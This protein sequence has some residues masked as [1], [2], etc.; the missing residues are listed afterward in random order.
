VKQ[1]QERLG[2]GDVVLVGIPQ[3]DLQEAERSQVAQAYA[4]RGLVSDVISTGRLPCTRH[5]VERILLLPT[6]GAYRQGCPSPQETPVPSAPSASVIT[7]P[8]GARQEL[9]PQEPAP[10]GRP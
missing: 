7:A 2:V 10:A 5:S 9:G 8:V 4:R 3:S 1:A 6:A